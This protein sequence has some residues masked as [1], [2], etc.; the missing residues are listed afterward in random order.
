MSRDQVS[1]THRTAGE[2]FFFLLWLYSPILGLGRL[3]ETFH[4]ISVTGS[5][6]VGWTPW[7]GDRLVAR[8]LL[9]ANWLWWW[10]SWWNERVWQGKPKYSEKTCP[11]AT[12]TTTNPTCQTR[13]GAVGSQRVTASSMARP[14]GKI[15]FFYILI[16]RF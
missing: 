7:T 13:A 12:L 16:F 11:D 8:S 14:T 6:T 1:P 10:R 9:T 2:V 3:H 5:R 4:F 15:I